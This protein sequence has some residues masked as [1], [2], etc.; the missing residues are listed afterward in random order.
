MC[1]CPHVFVVPADND[2]SSPHNLV[3]IDRMFFKSH[4]LFF[5]PLLL[6]INQCLRSDTNPN[7]TDCVLKNILFCLSVVLTSV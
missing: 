6:A 2:F 5:W 3:T 4:A 1:V 7:D